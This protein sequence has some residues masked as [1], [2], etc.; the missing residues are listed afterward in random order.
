VEV[1]EDSDEE[2][3]DWKKAQKVLQ[4]QLYAVKPPEKDELS[5]QSIYDLDIGLSSGRLSC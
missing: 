5:S 1:R 2:K 3:I 4:N